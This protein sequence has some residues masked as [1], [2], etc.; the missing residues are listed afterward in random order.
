M[1][2]LLQIYLWICQ[3]KN[4]ENQ[5]TF[6]EVMGKI[7]VLCFILTHSAQLA[8]SVSSP[9]MST[10]TTSRSSSPASSYELPLPLL[11]LTDRPAE[12]TIHHGE[13]GLTQC[14]RAGQPKSTYTSTAELPMERETDATLAQGA[15]PNQEHEPRHV[16]LLL[17]QPFYGPLSRPPGWAVTRRNIHPFTYPTFIS[18]FYP[19]QSIAFSVFNLYAWQSFCT[20]SRQVLFSAP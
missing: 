17:L 13:S 1:K 16:I 20:S 15:R 14:W 8:S 9:A 11:Q 6:G 19:L 4:F 12:L 10:S 2:I 18:F 5:S 3:W 7:I